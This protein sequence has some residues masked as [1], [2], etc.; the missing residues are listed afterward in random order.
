MK[1]RRIWI[2]GLIV[3]LLT[4]GGG[5]FAYTRTYGAQAQEP[6]EPTLET[7]TV[8]QGDITLTASGSGELIPAQE[9]ELSFRTGGR[10]AEVL[11][12][13]GDQV[14]EGDLL[15]RLETDA[16]ERAVAEADVELQIAQLE[17]ADVREGAS[18]AEIA[19]AEAALRDAQTQLTLAYDAYQDATDAAEDDAVEAAKENYDWWV[20]YYQKQKAL[21]EKGKI[22][23]TEHDWAMAAMI[24]AEEKWQR[25]INEAQV[26]QTQASKSL[27][28]AKNAVTQAKEDLELL[29]SEP[30]TDTLMEAEMNVD[31]ALLAREEA[32]ASLEAAQLCAP[33][34]GTVMD[35]AAEPGDRVGTDTTIL[36]L[37][38]MQEPLLRFWL[39]ESDMGNVAVGNQVNVTFE[40]LPDY[41]FTG[42]VVRVDPVLVTVDGTTAVQSQARLNLGDQNV[43]LLSGMTADVEVIS[44]ETRNALLVPVEALEE[45][46]DGRYVVSVVK[47]DGELE[48]REVEVG[49]KDA[50]NA[51]IL[52]GLEL[53]ETV[54][55]AG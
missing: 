13:T 54:R 11:V 1:K 18:E 55:I 38:E 41:T 36:T 14:A 2:I 46:S 34:S 35:V 27:E 5:Y 53:G 25:A 7:A 42:K 10:L 44:A 24:E 23:K 26:E 52:S 47:A 51:E 43:T 16:L 50:V 4:T 15:A 49:L 17:L 8:S 40:G 48:E 45:T 22:S 3:L 9:L 28:Q 12:E 32:Q 31:Q 37:A 19:D 33:F 6:E 39:E 20:S 29:K 30:L 21:Y